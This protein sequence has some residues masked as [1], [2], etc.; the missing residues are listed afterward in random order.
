MK[1]IKVLKYKKPELS[2]ILPC[3][4]E[5]KNLKKIFK[6]IQ[7]IN[8]NYQI[9]IEYI[10]VDNGSKDETHHLIK[11]FAAKSILQNIKLIKIKKNIG[12]GNGIYKGMLTAKGFYITWTHAD[13]QSD[14]LDCIFA[15]TKIKK[16]SGKIFIKGKRINRNKFDSFFTKIMSLFIRLY[17]G[18]NLEDI[19]GQPKLFDKNFKRLIKK[20][21]KDFSFD[22][23]CL[24]LA[25]KNNYSLKTIDVNFGKRVFGTAKGGGSIFG[26]IKLS[27]KTFLYILRIK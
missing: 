23:F 5:S 15:L 16:F 26:K 17:L 22:L 24:I 6:R 12:Y 8:K 21:P 1:K 19:N 10:F 13:L 18:Y 7:F 27:L 2:I 4:N 14:I 11:M 25:K 3:F 20:P 9:F